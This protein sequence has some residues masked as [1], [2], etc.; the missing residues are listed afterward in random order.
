MKRGD[1]IFL[2]RPERFL[3]ATVVESYDHFPALRVRLGN[4]PHQTLISSQGVLTAE[5]LS[6]LKM[7]SLK[8]NLREIHADL[9]LS[10]EP[11]MTSKQWAQKRGWNVGEWN[12]MK[13]LKRLGIIQ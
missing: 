9:I 7:K 2:K 11:G 5:E 13:Q 10:W 8:S 4:K 3:R 1:T 12:T 6:N